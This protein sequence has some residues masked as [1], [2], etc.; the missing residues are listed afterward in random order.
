MQ[1]HHIVLCTKKNS[2]IFNLII[3]KHL[4]VK[5]QT[6]TQTNKSNNL[7]LTKSEYHTT[8]LTLST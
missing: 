7:M 5:E 1:M 8:D 2:S 3:L 6:R 4:D